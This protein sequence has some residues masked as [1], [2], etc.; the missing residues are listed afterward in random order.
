M[1]TRRW[2]RWLAVAL[3]VAGLAVGVVYLW[4]YRPLQL[5]FKQI[6]NVANFQSYA[7]ALEIYRQ[8][9]GRYPSSLV[10]GESVPDWFDGRDS[11]GNPVVY[12]SDGAQYLLVSVGR[13]GR[14]DG[15]NWLEMRL[16]SKQG[17]VRDASCELFRDQILSDKGWYR[18]CGK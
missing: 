1:G 10:A 4:I 13:D 14:P 3:G 18:A 12:L 7:S 2:R 17:G 8:A 5:R 16:S 9:H 6:K 11:W 15:E